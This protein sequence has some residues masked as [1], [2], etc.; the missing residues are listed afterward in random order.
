MLIKT[1]TGHIDKELL[2]NLLSTHHLACLLLS[3]F[4]LQPFEPTLHHITCAATLPHR[5]GHPFPHICNKYMQPFFS[6]NSQ[7]PKSQCCTKATDA[8]TI[9]NQ[10]NHHPDVLHHT[11]PQSTVAQRLQKAL[12]QG[13]QNLFLANIFSC[14]CHSLRLPSATQRATMSH[15]HFDLVSLHATDAH[16]FFPMMTQCLPS[17]DACLSHD[18]QEAPDQPGHNQ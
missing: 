16:M 6:D 18:A 17:Q 10:A 7:H 5:I 2:R 4:I 11:L 14:L 8:R 3:S 1:T 9:H 13:T 12:Q 15:S